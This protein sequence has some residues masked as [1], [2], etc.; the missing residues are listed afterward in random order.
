M[1]G[2]PKKPQRL[3]LAGGYTT[4]MHGRTEGS[5]RKEGQTKEKENVSLCASL[6]CRTSGGSIFN[7]TNEFC[8]SYLFRIPW[9]LKSS[10]DDGN[11]R[12]L[13]PFFV[14]LRTTAVKLKKQCG[15]LWAA[16]AQSGNQSEREKVSRSGKKLISPLWCNLLVSYAESRGRG[17]ITLRFLSYGHRV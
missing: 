12:P 15:P 1:L 10:L 14:H 11:S 6:A 8:F 9:R 2:P 3:C 17:T 13:F 4:E 5:G 7:S 16:T